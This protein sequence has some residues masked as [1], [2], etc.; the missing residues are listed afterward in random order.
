[1]SS[2]NFLYFLINLTS[3]IAMAAHAL[4]LRK[5]DVNA[6]SLSQLT[7]SKRFLG[8]SIKTGPTCLCWMELLDQEINEGGVWV[9]HA[10]HSQARF[11]I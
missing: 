4:K 2:G 6:C 1:M 5:A 7:A 11:R 9:P 8:I 10:D 3:A